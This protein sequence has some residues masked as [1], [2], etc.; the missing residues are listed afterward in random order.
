MDILLK[1]DGFKV[2]EFNH[3][4]FDSVSNCIEM[5]VSISQNFTAKSSCSTS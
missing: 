5:E 2:L 1:R 3:I 4:L